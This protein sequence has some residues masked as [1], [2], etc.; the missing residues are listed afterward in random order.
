[1]LLPRVTVVGAAEP[2]LGS[3]TGPVEQLIAHGIRAPAGCAPCPAASLD[4]PVPAAARSEAQQADCWPRFRP[5]A[6][7]VFLL[8]GGGA[9]LA[10][11]DSVHRPRK[12]PDGRVFRPWSLRVLWIPLLLRHPPRRGRSRSPTAR[13][14]PWS[15]CAVRCSAST[16]RSSRLGRTTGRPWRDPA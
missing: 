15:R 6:P 9:G 5:H 14:M 4:S 11:G 3:R 13:P 12:A 7:A 8:R 10:A 1:M 2:P 16:S